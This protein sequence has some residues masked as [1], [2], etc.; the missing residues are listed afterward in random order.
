MGEKIQLASAGNDIKIWELPGL[1]A[2]TSLTPH[3]QPVTSIC[4]SGNNQSL[5]SVSSDKVVL[6][7]LKGGINR[8]T[9]FVVGD[10]HTCAAFNSTS[11]YL[12]LGGK[13]KTLTAWDVRSKSVK[14]TYKD[15]KDTV[16]CLQFN[17]NDTSIA[18]GSVDGNILLHNVVTAQVSQ[19]LRQPKTQAIRGLQFSHFKKA[20][21]ASVSDDGASNLWDTN[22][23]KLV[24]S[25]VN[26][27]KAPATALAFSPANEMLLTSVGL[28]KKIVFYDVQGKK[29][30]KV[31]T[32]DGPLTAVDFLDDGVTLV[33]GTTRGKVCVY[34]LRSGSS[35]I[36]TQAAHMSSVQCLRFQNS[37]SKSD[38]MLTNKTTKSATNINPINTSNQPGRTTTAPQPT[39][40]SSASVPNPATQSMVS[41]TNGIRGDD[42]E[43]FSPIREAKSLT[44]SSI[45][46]D[47]THTTEKDLK[48]NGNTIA[49]DSSGIFSPLASSTSASDSR[50][51]PVG[52]PAYSP[53]ERAYPITD[54]AYSP[55]GQPYPK[56]DRQPVDEHKPQ[57]P[58]PTSRPVPSTNNN[59]DAL[60]SRN[61]PPSES[62]SASGR[63]LE[64]TSNTDVQ[65][66]RPPPDS[67][68]VSRVTLQGSSSD[69]SNHSWKFADGPTQSSMSPKISPQVPRKVSGTS[70]VEVREPGVLDGPDILR[71][72]LSQP[73][74]TLANGPTN[75]SPP[76]M[77]T[78]QASGGLQPF[79]VEFIKNMIDDSMDE[80]RVAMH[81]DV[82][83][84]QVEML[85]QFHIQQ[86]ELR[87]MIEQYS[88]NEALVAEI[89]RLREENKR[90]KTKY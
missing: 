6:T 1:H 70:S 9:D 54:R 29:P 23:R 3:S 90:L 79:Q 43:V 72:N 35:P 48:M 75:T 26:E 77:V 37:S 44:T 87:K 13:T 32:A 66:T 21:L 64:E 17:W 89:E 56:T 67:N 42:V 5:A 58:E 24:T 65:G 12:L 86:M 27:H 19:P 60:S 61:R 57:Q 10:G 41:H 20:L 7:Y 69:S 45:R 14:K 80:F 55:T 36:N 22:S 8:S 31:I 51:R 16:S 34:D 74:S 53:T 82:V 15:H 46:V 83:N 50:H 39:P 63:L 47:D 84:L 88:V 2:L 4:W 33:V 71:T 30:V 62:S 11:R 81:K 68:Q 73:T 59:Q 52:G 28:D 38:S 85:R 25:F 49:P 78:Q 40:K 18:S 76:Q